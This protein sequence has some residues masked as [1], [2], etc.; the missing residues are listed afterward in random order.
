MAGS[1]R[2]NKDQFGK[3]SQYYERTW[4]PADELLYDFCK[5][6]PGHSDEAY[7]YSKV[8]LIDGAY[9]AG[10]AR[11]AGK[12]EEGPVDDPATKDVY[13]R[14]AKV[15]LEHAQQCDDII[16]TCGCLCEPFRETHIRT[17][18]EAHREFEKLF[19]QSGFT[20]DGAALRSF[21]S[22]Y[23]HFHAPIVPIIDSKAEGAAQSHCYLRNG[24]NL[25]HAHVEQEL[26]KNNYD[27]CYL[28][29]VC[30]WWCLFRHA[31]E[32][33]LEP[34]PRSLDVYLWLAESP[35]ASS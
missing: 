9:R 32:L 34:T 14:A 4:K 2:I 3:C 18:V 16:A 23:L 19:Q 26:G 24:P 12:L 31:Q 22:K 5:R 25:V 13:Y 7:V 1:C 17:A 33:G 35:P 11:T 28:C 30:R 8:F 20:R 29:F 10:I 6:Y 21:A 15:L 27:D